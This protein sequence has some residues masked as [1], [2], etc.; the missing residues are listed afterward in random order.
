MAGSMERHSKKL[1]IAIVD[2]EPSLC[3]A[4]KGLLGSEGFRALT[5]GS[6]EE[7]LN[8]TERD[9][10]AFLILDIRLPGMS[11]LEL[12][13]HLAALG[14]KVPVAFVTSQDDRDGRMQAQALQAGALALLPKPFSDEQLLTV[15][16][17]AIG[18]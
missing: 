11:G 14:Y 13:R 12:Q 7:F 9:Q 16:K 3:E 15:V 6:A 2:D 10:V 18:R 1:Y 5:F 4:I 8:S 17:A